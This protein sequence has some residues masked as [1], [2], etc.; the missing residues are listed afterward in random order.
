MKGKAKAALAVNKIVVQDK[1][2]IFELKTTK[3]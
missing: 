2:V 1:I 3:K